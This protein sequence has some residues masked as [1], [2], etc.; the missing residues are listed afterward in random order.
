[1]WEAPVFAWKAFINFDT[2]HLL[3]YWLASI[4]T[5]VRILIYFSAIQG[6]SYILIKYIILFIFLK[7]VL[8]VIAKLFE[9]MTVQMLLYGCENLTLLKLKEKRIEPTKMTLLRSVVWYTWLLY[10]HGTNEE[11]R[12]ELRFCDFCEIIMD[13]CC[14]WTQHLWRVNETRIPNFKYEYSLRLTKAKDS[15]ISTHEEGRSLE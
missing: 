1:M 3:D 6:M 4:S 9:I 10:D 13:H 11:I 2:S 5:S 14:K 15:G 7:K 8:I 12:G